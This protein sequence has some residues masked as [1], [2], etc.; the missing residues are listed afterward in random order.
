MYAPQY[1]SS[2]GH[3]MLDAWYFVDG[4]TDTIHMF[5]V[6]P[7][8]IGHAVSRDL[9]NWEE[10]VPVLRPGAPGT[11]DDLRLGAAG[12][13]IQ[14]GG[15]YWMAYFGT[16]SADS[17]PGEDHRVQRAG[18]AVSDDLFTWRKLPENPVT[19]AKAPHYEQMSTGQ[20]IA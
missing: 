9:V 6:V 10:L 16:S 13:I 18:I 17:W 4:G 14:R 12:S 11:W 7:E 20:R 8:F 3:S 19:Q 1:H 15:R 5:Y 2:N